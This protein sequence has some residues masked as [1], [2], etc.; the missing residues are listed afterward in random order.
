M[1]GI[2][3]QYDKQ[4]D[5]DAFVFK[6]DLLEHRGPDSS[7]LFVSDDK[8][9]ALGH[10]RLSIIDLSDR[11]RQP[12]KMGDYVIVYNGEVY[13][14][15]ELRKNLPAEYLSSS[16]TEVILRAYIKYGTEVFAMLDGMFA[17]C[18]YD[19]KNKQLV[20][21]RDRYGIKPLYY[22]QDDDNFF[23]ASELKCFN[24]KK[25]NKKSLEKFTYQYYVYGNET[26]LA[27]VNKL[28]SAS[29]AI[30]DLENK[31]LDIKEYWRPEFSSKHQ[32]DVEG[33]KKELHDV[34]S[35]SIKQSLISD[36]P[37]GVFLSSGIDSSLITAITKEQVDKVDTFTI[38]FDF[39]SF[40]ESKQ[41]GEI[42]EILGTNH[43]RV[44]LNKQEV[45]DEIP[46]ILDSFDEPF[47]DSSA[48]PTYFLTKF[49]K[50]KVTVCL[51]GDG[52]DELFGGYPI[53]YLPKANNLYRRL[54]FKNLI[55]K[56]VF[57]LPSSAGKMSLDY[58]LKR[59]VYA[60]KHPFTKAHFYYRIMHNQGILKDD[61]AGL[62]KDDFSEYF[63]LVKDEEVL[64]QLLYVD[65]KTVMEGDYL[66]KVDRMS[67]KNSLEVRVPFLN[68]Q[69]IDFANS[70]DP[71][72]KINKNHTKFILKKLLEDYLPK[73]LIYRKKQGFSFPIAAWLRY[74]L[75]DFILETLS[76]ENIINTNFLNQTKVEKMIN[77]HLSGKRD[78]NRE[79][80]A[81]MSLVRYFNKNNI[82]I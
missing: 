35:D 60:A 29:F 19:Q 1:C 56:G 42:A 26:I 79:L 4:I 70:L 74:E 12:M 45:L 34:L 55:E 3:G 49:A 8:K 25:I 15:N 77:D 68:N 31:I 80:W 5:T 43:H 78:Y 38:G 30:Y 7:G 51:S 18:I 71:K 24:Q 66:V 17:L 44:V 14:F 41:A 65:Q 28:P 50:E 36:V 16:D 40:D 22:S 46:N 61:F 39:S 11:A 64:N 75:K 21:A 67:M 47:G 57:V 63:E 33:V 72:L 27:G 23:F 76:T 81:L 54:P 20:L 37:L 13:N 59:F 6:R 48:I 73:E 58:K 9:V 82:E 53:Y 52:A 69:V 10:R 62:I 2:I 32:G